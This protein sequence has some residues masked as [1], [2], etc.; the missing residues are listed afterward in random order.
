MKSINYFLVW[1][2]AVLLCSCSDA[3][4]LNEPKMSI[5][6]LPLTTRASYD[7]GYFR[8]DS[9][10]HL[11]YK[12]DTDDIKDNLVVPWMPGSTTSIGIP[13][14]WI[15]LNYQ[16]PDPNQRKYSEANGWRLVYSNLLFKGPHDKYFVLYNKYTGIMRMFFIRLSMPSQAISDKVFVGLRVKG[17]SSLLNFATEFPLGMSDRQTD[18]ATFFTPK[19]VVFDGSTVGFQTDQW[20]GMEVELAYDSNVLDSNLLY[21]GIESLNEFATTTS[22]GITGGI[23]GNVVTTYSNSPELKFEINNSRTS[24]IKQNF[25]SA[26]VSI[27]QA[28]SNGKSGSDSNFWNGIWNKVKSKVPSIASSA[29]SDGISAIVSGGSSLAT[30]ALGFLTKSIFGASSGPMSSESKV[31]L[32]ANLTINSTSETKT[33]AVQSAINDLPLPGSSFQNVL[34]DEKLGV[35][36]LDVT[37]T[38]YVDMHAYSLFYTQSQDKSKSV[39]TQVIYK[40]YLSPCSLQINP[41]VSC[42]FNVANYSLDLVLDRTLINNY[43]ETWNINSCS[44]YGVLGNVKLY[45]PNTNDLTFEEEYGIG[46][47]VSTEPEQFF[48]KYWNKGLS[49]AANYFYCR[50]SFD[51]VS[52]SDNNKVYSFSKYFKVNPVKRNFYHKNVNI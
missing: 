1:Y 16:N 24:T 45:S 40:Y 19:S 9:V 49:N 51:L 2:L 4:D 6:K 3:D 39:A 32:G 21:F 11:V 17:S 28:I 26:A 52:K 14:D 13:S 30:K 27:G 44:P 25:N 36:N 12:L 42:D 41:S 46:R 8:W 5:S 23:T 15:D 34:F 48:N 43:Q 37:P 35:W 47:Y 20:Y 7:S 10:D 50:V 18:C 31:D 29:V 38:I 22:G 33:V